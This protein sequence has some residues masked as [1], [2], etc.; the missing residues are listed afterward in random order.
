MEDANGL[1]VWKF[2]SEKYGKKSV[3]NTVAQN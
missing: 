1:S 2:S 3:W